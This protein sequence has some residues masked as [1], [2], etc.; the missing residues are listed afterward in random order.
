M[1]LDQECVGDLYL[2]GKRPKYGSDWMDEAKLQVEA[3]HLELAKLFVEMAVAQCEVNYDY[4]RRNSMA[5]GGR[6]G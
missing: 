3:G 5:R 1:A 2:G 4:A 6:A